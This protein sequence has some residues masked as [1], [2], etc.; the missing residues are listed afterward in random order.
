MAIQIKGDVA[1]C[2]SVGDIEKHENFKKLSKTQKIQKLQ[3]VYDE[4]GVH[5]NEFFI[6]VKPLIMWTIYRNLRGMPVT[7]LEDLVNNAY[8]ELI[9]AF[10]GGKTT[11]YNEPI[12][13][14]AVYGTEKYYTK[15]KNIGDFIMSE[16][17][18]AVAKYRSKTY[19]RKLVH[20][21]EGED[22][23]ERIHY[24]NFEI[25]NN[26]DYEISEPNYTKEFQF[27]KFNEEL[28]NH[29]EVLKETKP[30]NNVL[31]NFM[32]WKESVSH[33]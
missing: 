5:S 21:D 9:I 32:L 10:E 17:G 29:L 11:H 14:E 31:Y 15:Y 30:R 6:Q 25:N 23:S 26:L 18:S 4:Y 27:F 13:K 24:T 1:I 7:Y 2:S 12:V 22:I 16:V 20:E 28:T 8:E 33:V 3:E 19:R